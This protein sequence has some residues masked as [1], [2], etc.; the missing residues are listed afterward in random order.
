MCR[1][2][3]V[4]DDLGPGGPGTIDGG[5]F[6]DEQMMHCRCAAP[7][8]AVMDRV[9]VRSMRPVEDCISTACGLF[10]LRMFVV[11]VRLS[12][13]YSCPSKIVG[14]R[15]YRGS[16]CSADLMLLLVVGDRQTGGSLRCQIS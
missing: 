5:Q 1:V 12:V 2:G 8:Q 3:S 14:E 6:P 13:M 10:I 9:R 11:P 16:F 15:L 4:C 7:H